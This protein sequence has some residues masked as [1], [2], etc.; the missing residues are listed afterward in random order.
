MT[1]GFLLGRIA[2]AVCSADPCRRVLD[3][4]IADLQHDY[5]RAPS[6]RR[7]ISALAA[8]YAAFW[9]SLGWCVVIDAR[10]R[11][12]REFNVRA[13][14]AFA[15]TVA[16]LAAVEELMMHASLATNSFVVRHVWYVGFSAMSD[17][18]TLR[19]GVPLAMFPAL[20]Y[21]TRRSAG[22]TRAAAIRTIALGAVVTVA[23]SGWIAPAFERWKGARQRDA[24]LRDTGGRIYLP[25]VEEHAYPPNDSWPDLFRGAVAPDRHRYPGYPTYVAPEDRGLREFYRM[26]IYDRLFLIDLALLAGLLGRA[27]GRRRLAAAAVT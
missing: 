6:T 21:A 26:T 11:E 2:R 20:F 22:F 15:I 5:A 23:S 9:Q 10:S 16:T 12:S 7:R 19:F 13:A 4:A 17:T 24:F 3:P 1:P 25:P 8:G 14:V 18:A 27:A